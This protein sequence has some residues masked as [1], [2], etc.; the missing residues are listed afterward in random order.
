MTASL[1]IFQLYISLQST[2]LFYN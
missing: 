2:T 1:N